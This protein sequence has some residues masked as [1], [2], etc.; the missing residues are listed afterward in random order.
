MC[1]TLADSQSSFKLL[2]EF[3]FQLDQSCHSNR[4]P[5]QRLISSSSADRQFTPTAFFTFILL[6]NMKNKLLTASAKSG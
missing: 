1:L 5:N 2:R 4:D 3:I 6:K